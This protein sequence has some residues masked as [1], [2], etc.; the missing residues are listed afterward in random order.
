MR[1]GWQF[2]YVPEVLYEYRVANG[3][4]IKRA[5]SYHEETV[6][7]IGTKYGPQYRTELMQLLAERELERN[8][9]R[10]AL[11]NLRRIIKT[12][13]KQRFHSNGNHG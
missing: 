9:G 5:Q 7:F 8:S 11:H 4:M 10:A 1:H 2:S 3:S 12:R 13:L 6:K